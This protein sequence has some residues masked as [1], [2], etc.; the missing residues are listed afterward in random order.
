MAALRSA[1]RGDRAMTLRDWLTSYGAT[2][3]LP[4]PV[5][6]AMAILAILW[7]W[8]FETLG[9]AIPADEASAYVFGVGMVVIFVPAFSWLGLIISVPLVWLVLRLGC[10][11]WLSFGLGGAA[12][13][14]LAAAMLGGMAA[15]V[16]V[17]IGVL[18]G[19][20]FWSILRWL[21]PIALDHS[22]ASEA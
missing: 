4:I 19:L 1:R 15:P 8:P 18:S 5:G 17:G 2:W 6:L 3:L 20:A 16:P 9:W 10:G 7:R 11:G 14:R 22:K 13:G 12:S 21:R